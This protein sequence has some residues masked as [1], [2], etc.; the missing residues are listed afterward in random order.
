M[1]DYAQIF[2]GS[3]R[4][5]SPRNATRTSSQKENTQALL[6]D[7]WFIGPL[8]C[9]L[10]IGVVMTGS[11]SI[12]ISDKETNQPLYYLMR[13][14]SYIGVGLLLAFCVLQV[15]L[16]V[17]QR[18]GPYLLVG[19][20][21]LLILVL[22]PGIGLQ[23]NGSAR[24]IN[25]GLVNLQP[26]EFAKLFF[27]IYLAGY[28]ERRKEEIQKTLKGF[29]IPVVL[30]TMT[31]LLLFVE[32]DFGAIVVLAATVF[33]MLFLAG[34]RLLHF[35][36]FVAV[37]VAALVIM[38]F[39][40]PYRIER[41]VT[42]LNPWDDPFDSGFQLTQALIAFGRGE[43]FGVGL[44]SSV[45]K[46]FYLPEAHTDFVFAVIAEELGLAGSFIVIGLFSVVI[47]KIFCVASLAEKIENSFAAHLA[48]GIGLW[49]GLQV[50]INL[51]VNMGVLPTKGLT[52]P[53]MSYGGSSMVAVCVA[54]A[55]VV[56]INHEVRC[57][58]C[59]FPAKYSKNRKNTRRAGQYSK[60]SR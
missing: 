52:L 25:L 14:I 50:I 5:D 21:I 7:Y 24:W 31:S 38:S 60:K 12:G 53:L 45:Q 9:L 54:L 10:C 30:L 35:S 17:W 1:I 33:G 13:Q 41:L 55:I 58:L 4:R 29:L 47:W 19:A 36:I 48:Y 16:S 43:W 27:V 34:V 57:E 49:L 44:G 8:V 37:V 56:R 28:L 15:R 46:L 11:A 32:P 18:F 26:S 2:G 3:Q 20:I 6:I 39:S 23:I 40:A 22:I 42:F 51:G 59:A